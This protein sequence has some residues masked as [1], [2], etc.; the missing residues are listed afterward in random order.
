M[1]ER[2]RKKKTVAV[3]HLSMSWTLISY[4]HHLFFCFFTQKSLSNEVLFQVINVFAL[5]EKTSGRRAEEKSIEREGK[6]PRLTLWLTLQRNPFS[7][8]VSPHTP[9]PPIPPLPPTSQT[10]VIKTTPRRCAS[11]TRQKM[12]QLGGSAVFMFKKKKKKKKVIMKPCSAH[13]LFVLS[14][15]S[16]NLKKVTWETSPPLPFD[17]ARLPATCVHVRVWARCRPHV[18]VRGSLFGGWRWCVLPCACVWEG[19]SLLQ[20]AFLTR[21]EGINPFFLKGGEHAKWRRSST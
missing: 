21:L 5:H 8:S 7:H 16:L 3:L 6:K 20:T 13:T 2:G 12:T 9:P 1:Q 10:H 14:S 19:W 17:C 11:N 15:S 18:C 4:I